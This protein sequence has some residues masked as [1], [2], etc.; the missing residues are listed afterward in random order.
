MK[1]INKQINKQGNNALDVETTLHT[2]IIKLK[3]IH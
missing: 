1:Y 2:V 3:R